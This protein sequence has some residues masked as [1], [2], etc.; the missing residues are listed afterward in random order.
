LQPGAYQ[1]QKKEEYMLKLN[2]DVCLSVVVENKVVMEVSYK[3]PLE[4]E[5]GDISSL[6]LELVNTEGISPKEREIQLFRESLF[7]FLDKTLD[8]NKVL[9]DIIK[10]KYDALR[11]EPT[12]AQMDQVD[13]QLEAMRL[14]HDGDLEATNRWVDDYNDF[15]MGRIGSDIS[16]RGGKP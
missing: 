6:Q 14:K 9:Q 4:I 12:A 7:K 1:G 13:R 5:S 8:H 3:M 2:G 15:I 10:R 11:G 16:V